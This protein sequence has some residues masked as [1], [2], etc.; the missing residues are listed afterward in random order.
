MNSEE[1]PK[2]ARRV[3]WWMWVILILCMAPGLSFPWAVQM[4]EHADT[5][6]RG[7]IWFYPCYVLCSGFLAWQCYGRRTYMTWIILALL[8]LS[9]LC[10]Y[11]LAFAL[12]GQALSR[13]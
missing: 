10:F 1:T 3:P 8:V 7:L 11:Y 9:H 5:L 2:T 13:I 6:A 12:L 4:A